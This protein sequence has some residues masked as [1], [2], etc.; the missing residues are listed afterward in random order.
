M[1]LEKKWEEA[2]KLREKIEEMYVVK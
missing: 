1:R 2:D